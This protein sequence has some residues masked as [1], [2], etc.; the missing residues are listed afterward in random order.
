MA[1]G[2]EPTPQQPTTDTDEPE[3]LVTPAPPAPGGAA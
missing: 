2:S 3:V 1:F